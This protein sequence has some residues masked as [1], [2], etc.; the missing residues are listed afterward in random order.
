MKFLDV[1]IFKNEAALNKLFDDFRRKS[2]LQGNQN[3]MG[4]EES[5]TENVDRLAREVWKVSCRDKQGRQ[6]D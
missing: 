6:Q 2:R 5:M 1:K 3:S 4:R